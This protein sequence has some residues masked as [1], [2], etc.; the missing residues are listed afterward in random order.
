MFETC[1]KQRVI[2]CLSKIYMMGYTVKLRFIKM[3]ML[4]LAA[5]LFLGIA[6]GLTLSFTRPSM[7]SSKSDV[8]DIYILGG[9]SARKTLVIVYPGNRVNF[10][11]LMV[12]E[13]PVRIMIRLVS[14]PGYGDYVVLY[15]FSKS[16]LTLSEEQRA[17]T[18]K[19]LFD[20]RETRRLLGSGYKIDRIRPVYYDTCKTDK[21]FVVLTR[22]GETCIS[23][24]NLIDKKVE[25]L[26]C[27]VKS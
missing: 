9:D 6:I 15:N 18:I 23:L 11:R 3:S 10:T 7:L 4:L 24:V 16:N 22:N 26:S 8:G 25:F 2:S 12:L 5:S 27:I 14:L 19:I 21:T 17:T 1:F 13:K 20:C